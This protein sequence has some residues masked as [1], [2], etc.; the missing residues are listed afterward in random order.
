MDDYGLKPLGNA[1]ISHLRPAQVDR[2]WFGAPYYP[3]HWDRE[4]REKDPERMAAAGFNIVRMAEFAWDLMEPKEGKYD[5]SFFDEIIVRLGE[6]GIK[7]ILCTPTAAPPRWFTLKYPGTRRVND[8]GVTMQHGS[9]QHCCHSNP[10]FRKHSRL[11]TKAMAGHFRYNHY[12]SGWQ[13]DNEINCHF[14][15]CHCGSCQQKFRKFL[16]WKYQGDIAILNK[17][18]GNA[19][20]ALTYSSFDEIETPK[21]N[22]PAYCNPSAELDYFRYLSHIA[23]VFQHEQV[24]ILRNS[25]PKWFVTHNGIFGHLDYRGTFTK[26]LDFLSYDVYPMFQNDPGLRVEQNAYNLDRAR[27]LSGNFMIPEHQ[28]GPGGQAPYFHDNPEPG[29]IRNMTY[30]AVARGC[31]SILYFRW[32]T[33][34][35]GA[36]EYWSGILDHDNRPRRRYDEIAQIGKEMKTVGKVILGTSVFIDCAVATGDMEVNDAHTTYPLGLPSPGLMAGGAHAMLY[37]SGYAVGCVHPSDN[38]SGLKLYFIQN[39]ELF[40]PVWLLNLE[41]YVKD[42]GVLVVGARTATRD[43][44]NNVV[45][46][47]IPGCLRELAGITVEE[48]GKL[49]M[50]DKRPFHL[51][52]KDRKIKSEIWY[53]ILH[54]ENAVSFAKWQGRHLD[55][56]TAISIR[57]VGK[58]RVIYAGT[59][60]SKNIL[61]ILMPE[62]IEIANL[63][64]LWPSAPEGVETVVRY[65]GKKKIWFFINHADGKV[66]IGKT[67]RGRDLVSGKETSGGKITLDRYELAVI[68]EC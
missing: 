49:N 10:V 25:Q 34:R 42:G 5:F 3:E 63:K 19:F 13:T 58:G 1:N 8:N 55:G 68:L 26:D 15:E 4:T 41:K 38:L 16:K 45:A 56:K 17:A 9:R 46:E 7:T 18:W 39:W 48:Y 12:V 27:S 21:R 40:N 33:C 52:F 44:N 20:W 37:K 23:T 28:S 6:K 22:K 61:K 64:P 11:I 62:F 14:S 67:P 29:E 53:E 59:Y 30:R 57:K 2:F 32:R 50:P 31:D 51:K 66:K 24:E 54:L 35:F 60:L 47:T 36:E 43:M 65:N